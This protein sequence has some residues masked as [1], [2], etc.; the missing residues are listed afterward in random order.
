MASSHGRT[1]RRK[2]REVSLYAD[3]GV[4]EMS[5]VDENNATSIFR[6]K[7]P[8]TFDDDE[9]ILLHKAVSRI[10]DDALECNLGSFDA[11]IMTA[12]DL[13]IRESTHLSSAGSLD[14]NG[15]G[16]GR[17]PSAYDVDSSQASP[18]PIWWK[19]L[20]SSD[21]SLLIVQ[22]GI[23]PSSPSPT[24]EHT[25]GKSHRCLWPAV[26]LF[27][28]ACVAGGIAGVVSSFAKT[29]GKSSASSAEQVMP[30]SIHSSE[31]PSESPMLSTK[32]SFDP[33]PKPSFNPTPKPVVSPS[34]SPTFPPR[35]SSPTERLSEHP[36]S[37]TPKE[38]PRPITSTPVLTRSAQPTRARSFRELMLELSP[39]TE[40]SLKSGV[41]A[42]SLALKRID[43]LS[44]DFD[45]FALLTLGYA[46][47]LTAWTRSTGMPCSW[48]GVKCDSNASVI[49]VELRHFD[50]SGTLPPELAFATSMQVLAIAGSSGV[51]V[52]GNI[53]G[54][55]PPLW[56]ELMTNL[57]II[58][59]YDNS[60]S[61][62]IPNS[63]WR[64][65]ALEH[66]S[67]DGNQLT[68]TFP[69]SLGF[70]TSLKS[71]D[72]SDNDL[73]GSLPEDWF[74]L[75]NL[76]LLSLENNR[77]YGSLPSGLAHLTKL[78]ELHLEKNNFWERLPDSLH[79][80]TSLIWISAQEN[81][82][83]G[84]LPSL[85]GNIPNLEG[86]ELSKNKLTG[87]LPPSFAVFSNLRILDLS[88]N[89]LTGEIPSEWD[90]MQSEGALLL[91]GNHLEGTVSSAICHSVMHIQSDCNSDMHC[92]CCSECFM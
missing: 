64:L 8:P 54:S 76:H 41:S 47:K 45:R 55:I 40:V 42:Q 7:P 71:L 16:F 74:E 15:D 79:S 28:I 30:L 43:D 60:L 89:F 58:E 2:I 38:T 10:L 12:D 59:L 83:T 68:G 73:V 1:S 33:T 18:H 46:T 35:T 31:S 6:L 63:F 37:A 82:L 19:G 11:E 29:S 67:L 85:L 17:V 77:M 9:S 75:S 92:S 53:S 69:S 87:S 39:T 66:L 49:R 50:L 90:E 65:S 84:T 24:V 81:Q 25:C 36:A 32:P 51:N 34:L 14:R 27:I 61:G 13:Q 5:S 78:Q 57:R 56:G 80:L 48:I 62:P 86:L 20:A 22:E 26:I 3:D 21:K 88:N 72:C 44:K 4:S 70:M 52:K 91:Q 23:H